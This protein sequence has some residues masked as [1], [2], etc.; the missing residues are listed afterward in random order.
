MKSLV[1]FTNEQLEIMSKESS[2][3]GK[4]ARYE[5]ERRKSQHPLDKSSK[6][7][8]TGAKESSDGAKEPSDGAEDVLQT[9]GDNAPPT[10]EKTTEASTEAPKRSRKTTRKRKEV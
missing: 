9:T 2:P 5:I 1:D 3:R 10:E 6:Q 8:D 7:L 4:N